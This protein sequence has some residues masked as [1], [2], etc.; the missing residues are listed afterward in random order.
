[1]VYIF[2]NRFEFKKKVNMTFKDIHSATKDII[3]NWSTFPESDLIISSRI[4]SDASFLSPHT[5]FSSRLRD[6][7]TLIGKNL[8][9]SLLTP[10]SK[11][12]TAYSS[13]VLKTLSDSLSS[14]LLTQLENKL[15]AIIRQL[16]LIAAG[17]ASKDFKKIFG[18][19]VEKVGEPLKRC[20]LQPQEII[21]VFDKLGEELPTTFQAKY[22]AV[23][24]I[25]LTTVKNFLTLLY[26]RI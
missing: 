14:E 15:P 12:A 8:S 26:D 20:E 25:Y 3:S 2:T 23:W 16:I 6:L 11:T 21:L 10:D 17:T 4:A 24:K 7:K 19:W 18:D 22:Q 5:K 13:Q 1:M 9:R